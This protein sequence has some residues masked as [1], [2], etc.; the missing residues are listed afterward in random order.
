MG[1]VKL[2]QTLKWRVDG[3]YVDVTRE[4]RL[5]A[6]NL[7]DASSFYREH[8][9]VR[10]TTESLWLLRNYDYQQLLVTTLGWKAEAPGAC[11]AAGLVPIM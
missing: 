11:Y 3:E 7:Q 8:F 9:N 5:S 1:D 6:A 10:S 4:F 2:S